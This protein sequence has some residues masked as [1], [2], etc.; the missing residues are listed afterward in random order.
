MS[1]SWPCSTAAIWVMSASLAAV[2]LT[3][4]T[5]P[6]ATSTPVCPFIPKRQHLRVTRLALV[7]GRGWGGNDRGVDDR[8]LAHQQATLLQHRRYFGEQ[9]LAQLML[10]QPM[11]EVPDCRLLRD[12]RHR[13]I[14]T[15]K[16]AQGLAIVQRI[17]HRTVGQ[18]I[19]LLQEVDPQHPLQTD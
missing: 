15:G 16:A 6:D 2:P 17:L 10:L 4:C 8:P 11:A 14:N 13:Q 19:P 5:R 3:V 18:P 9:R 1:L 12:R 7:L